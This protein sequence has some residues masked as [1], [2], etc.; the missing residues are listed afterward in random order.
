MLK[1]LRKIVSVLTA[2]LLAVL[3]MCPVCAFS[4]G[5]ELLKGYFTTNK[6]VRPT[7]IRAGDSVM[8]LPAYEPV[9]LTVIDRQWGSMI[10]ENGKTGYVFYE[11]LLPMPEFDSLP[12][13]EM[14]SPSAVPVTG[15]PLEEAPSVGT[16]EAWTVCVRDGVSGSWEHIRLPESGLSGYIPSGSLKEPVFT[17]PDELIPVN[18]MAAEPA[19][20]TVLPLHGAEVTGATECETFFTA[21]EAGLN[22]HLVLKDG[23]SVSYIRKKDVCI[24]EID[25][26]SNIPS[27][28]IANEEDSAA[29]VLTFAYAGDGTIL[30]VPGQEDTPLPSGEKLFV[31]ME[32]SG[33]LAVTAGDLSGFV[34]KSA[35]TPETV[36]TKLAA[37]RETDLSG[38]SVTRNIY[39]DQGFAMLE[40]QNS[41]LLRYNAVTDAG[42]EALFP[43]GVPYFWGGRS[44]NILRGQHPE[45]ST[46]AAWQSSPLYYRA[47]TIYLYGFDCVGFVKA[48]YSLAKHPIVEALKDLFTWEHC[49]SGHHVWCRADHPMPADWKEVAAAMEPGDILV[50]FHPGEH[51]MMYMGTL[52]QYGYTEEQL[53]LLADYLDYPLMLQSG[54]DP[55]CYLR[56][57]D[58]I[59]SSDNERVK[60][61]TPAD[62][63]VSISILGV[64][65]EEAEYILA[66][67]C[68]NYP[69]F[70]VEGSCV[71]VF[72]FDRVTNYVVYRKDP[73]IAPADQ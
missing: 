25:P 27:F 44:Y 11:G 6:I 51:V 66:A 70:L 72:D 4:E 8:V 41:F 33:M 34:K 7:M 32:Y 65:V 1:H 17:L 37:L 28:F 45:Y 12:E 46:L 3:S 59:L 73:V 20:I 61:A 68:T 26:E 69:F 58:Y 29:P 9:E 52:R 21:Y 30:H 53:P 15:L 49:H 43:N 13:E 63:G 22:E 60:R 14:Y 47:G 64:P 35:V 19:E 42:I 55:F 71:N 36:E 10:L 38:A 48:V 5:P 67:P 18:V 24:C 50:V 16:L 2:I 23:E 31:Y 62:G 56:F 54:E 57:T 40:E 39:L